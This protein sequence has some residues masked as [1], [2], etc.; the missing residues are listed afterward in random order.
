MQQNALLPKPIAM[1]GKKGRWILLLIREQ[2]DHDDS[3]S[4]VLK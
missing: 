3:I 4:N 1:A 2:E